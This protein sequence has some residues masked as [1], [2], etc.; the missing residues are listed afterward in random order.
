METQ[1]E[2]SREAYERLLFRRD[3]LLKE[4]QQ[5][6]DLYLHEFGELLTELFR[7]KV[8]CIEKKKVI[9]FCLTRINRGIRIDM[10]EMTAYI[11]NQM[12]A[13]RQQL[14]DLTRSAEA[15]REIIPA[16]EADV[17]KVKSLYRSIAKKIHPDL[18]AFTA[19]N[20]ELQTLWN[21]VVIAYKGNNRE[22][23]EELSVQIDSVLRKLGQDIEDT[24][25]P[26]IGSKIQ[27]LEKEIETII[28]TDPYQYQEILSDSTLVREKKQNLERVITEYTEYETLL[29]KKL[30]EL[31]E[32][33][34]QFN[35]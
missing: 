5:Y 33:G 27:A 24:V 28:T 1:R 17:L 34:A 29:K 7:L 2:S 3:R 26:D 20:E 35:L 14:A 11:D 32:G 12:A 23:I 9:A 13:F 16:P 22:K 30:A 10:N 25:I 18:C 19:D 4:A 31:I 8:S 21:A 6:L 15:C